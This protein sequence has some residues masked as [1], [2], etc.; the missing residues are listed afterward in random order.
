VEIVGRDREEFNELQAD[1]TGYIL[2]ELIW[3][4][5]NEYRKSWWF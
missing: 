3:R 4:S 2:A 5:K 1:G